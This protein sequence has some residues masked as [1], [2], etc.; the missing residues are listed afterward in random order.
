MLAGALATFF[1]G[2]PGVKAF[3]EIERMPSPLSNLI[4]GD[5]QTQAWLGQ[6]YLDLQPAERSAH[7]L[8]RELFGN[9]PDPCSGKIDTA[10]A[11]RHVRQRR[12]Q[13]FRQGEVVILDGWVLTRTEARVFALVA[14]G[15]A[16]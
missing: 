11:L 1:C 13:D 12:E 7:R 4:P 14:V 3:T 2:L 15:S 10:A 8:Y 5:L 16:G 9:E 6:C